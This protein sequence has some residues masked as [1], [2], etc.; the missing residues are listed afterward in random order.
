MARISSGVGIGWSSARLVDSV[1][2]TYRPPPEPEVLIGAIVDRVERRPEGSLIVVLQPAW[3]SIAKLL[4]DNPSELPQLSPDQWEELIAGAYDKA[5][6]DEVVLTPR[7]GDGGRDIIAVKRGYHSIRIIDQVK[8]YAPGH[9]VPANDVR[10][11]VG[12][13]LSDPLATKGIVTTTSTFAPRILD[14]P[15]IARHMPFRLELHDGEEV[16]K[17]L[18]ALTPDKRS[19]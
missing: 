1:K 19:L 14:D 9:P 17:R 6:Y 4:R 15:S 3:D 2:A 8:A 16:R 11:L 18:L 10:A 12:V 13:L 7:S 5:G